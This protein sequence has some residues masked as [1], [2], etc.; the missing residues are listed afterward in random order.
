MKNVIDIPQ[1]NI[2]LD[3]D[4]LL[5]E[6]NFDQ[7]DIIFLGGSLIEGNFIQFSKGMG[8]KYSDIDLFIISDNIE[9]FEYQ[10]VAYNE[11]YYQTKFISFLGAS[12]DIEILSKETFNHAITSFNNIDFSK[13]SIR[14][15]NLLDLE[16]GIDFPYI[17]SFIHR[18]LTGIPIFNNDKYKEIKDSFPKENYFHFMSRH[19]IN[20][21][22]IHYEDIVGNLECGE[23]DTSIIIARETLLTV[24]R[25]YLY[26][27]KISIDRDKWILLKLKNI[28]DSD[29]ESNDIYNRFC[30]LYYAGLEN[31]K[32]KVINIEGIID[33]T[34]TIISI[35]GERGGV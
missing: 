9:N 24:S 35:I 25:A 10:N 4:A 29:Q 7:N 34:N 3:T 28:G 18:F 5:K 12:I 27:K 31:Q 6:L 2:E 15:I 32:A 21:A 17:C 14:T 20:L 13:T 23:F 16:K 11:K 33:Y 30:S 26:F 22:D 8:N 1:R 19:Y